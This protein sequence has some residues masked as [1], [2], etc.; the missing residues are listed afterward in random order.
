M[1][2][3]PLRDA[4]QW[5]LDDMH[6]NCETHNSDTGQPY[7]SVAAAAEAL[8]NAGGHLSWYKPSTTGY[9]GTIRVLLKGFASNAQAEAWMVGVLLE[10]M[11]E[12]NAHGL[13]DFAWMFSGAPTR[14]VSIPV[15]YDRDEG[16]P[17]PS[18]KLVVDPTIPKHILDY[19]EA[20]PDPIG[21]IARLQWKIVQAQRSPADAQRILA[22]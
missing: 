3:N 5:L 7:D 22:S 14:E 10:L 12:T 16:D 2:D 1:S 9:V 6:D 18:P 19:A 11:E 8:V 17:L 4:L 20:C 21:E 15:D 13:L